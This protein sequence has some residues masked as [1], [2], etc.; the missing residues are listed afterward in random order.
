LRRRAVYSGSGA[1][2]MLLFRMFVEK[3]KVHSAEIA[4]V[5]AHIPVLDR[6]SLVGLVDRQCVG[7]RRS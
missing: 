1:P 6:K 3:H 2:G 5:A 4:V 7:W